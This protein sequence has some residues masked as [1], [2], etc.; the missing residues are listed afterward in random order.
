MGTSLYTL[1]GA[2]MVF[3]VCRGTEHPVLHGESTTTKEK[4]KK[5]ELKKKSIKAQTDQEVH[6]DSC[7]VCSACVAARG[8]REKKSPCN[9]ALLLRRPLR[10]C[11]PHGPLGGPLRSSLGRLPRRLLGSP[12]SSPLPRSLLRCPLGRLPGSPPH[13]LPGSPLRCRP[14]GSRLFRSPPRRSPLHCGLARYLAGASLPCGGLSDCRRRSSHDERCKKKKERG[15][16]K[17]ES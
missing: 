7:F 15:V 9:T 3:F 17:L 1:E 14:P 16:E 2:E 5:N 12:L 13:S 6:T 4:R 8:R 10:G 11:L